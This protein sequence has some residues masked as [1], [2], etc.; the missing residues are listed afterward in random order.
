MVRPRLRQKAGVS[1]SAEALRISA[2]TGLG[3]HW[4][5]SANSAGGVRSVFFGGQSSAAWHA[6]TSFA[7]V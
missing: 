5:M 1:S 7:S 3:A 2:R 6:L 4:T